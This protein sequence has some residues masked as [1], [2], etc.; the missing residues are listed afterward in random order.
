MVTSIL[1]RK[2]KSINFYSHILSSFFD[3]YKIVE[4]SEN[5]EEYKIKFVSEKCK[6][7]ISLKSDN[8]QKF[9]Q[10][11]DRLIIS[12]E[13]GDME[14]DC[15]YDSNT[16]N[17]DEFIKYFNNKKDYLEEK[18][19][20][21]FCIKIIKSIKNEE[22]TIYDINIFAKTIKDKKT[23]EFFTI[24]SRL[25]NT[26]STIKFKV[27]GLE[28]EFYSSSIFFCGIHD[29]PNKICIDKRIDIHEGFKSV[30]HYTDKDIDLVPSDFKLLK[31][32]ENQTILNNLFYRYSI[33]L[34]I[35]YLFDITSLKGDNFEF[36]ING[37]KSIKG[38]V[39]LSSIDIENLTEYYDIYSWVYNGGNLND[40]IGLA[41][42]IITLHFEDVN[43]LEI[44][45]DLFQSVK[46]S[47][48]IYEKE[49]I[50]EYID[51]RNKISDQLLDFNNRANKIVEAFS[52]NLQKNAFGLI[53]Y[54][55][56]IIIL[57]VLNQKETT[58]I[59]TMKTTIL[60]WGFI[61]CSLIYFFV[62]DWEI[63]KQKKRF[64]TSYKNLKERYTDLLEKEDI[65]RILNK[66]K[67]YQDDLNFIIE[68]KKYYKIMW[69]SYLVILFLIPF[70]L[71]DKNSWYDLSNTIIYV[72]ITPK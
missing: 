63:N 25:L 2:M 32:D 46:S 11:R 28:K 40:K 51:I 64:E 60:S 58:D 10:K 5:H 38:E 52:N 69:I 41:R 45:G 44:Q 17:L 33:V 39:D 66:D 24:F 37:Y 50:K 34:S 59:F 62:A 65:N 42:N 47:Y 49:N 43:K 61:L 71:S 9:L 4:S 18:D 1:G 8:F 21:K 36:K 16:N 48:K 57:K 26:K 14:Q 13:L 27:L 6:E 30:C 70:F 35:I 15:N 31:I 7:H 72:W 23:S 3:D 56:S 20:I 53:S 19:K 68:K 67:D 55:A 12:A 22:C 29:N 54:Y